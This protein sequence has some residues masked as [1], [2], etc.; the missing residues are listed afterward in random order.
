MGM[1]RHCRLPSASKLI[2]YSS[3]KTSSRCRRSASA[4]LPADLLLWMTTEKRGFLSYPDWAER[5][6]CHRTVVE[7]P[8][9]KRYLSGYVFFSNHVYM[10][11]S[12]LRDTPEDIGRQTDL[13]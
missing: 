6:F 8:I 13:I 1:F 4:V 11:P 2:P 10:L 12:R 5:P 9:Q 3:C 7:A